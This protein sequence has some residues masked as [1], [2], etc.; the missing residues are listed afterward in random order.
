[1]LLHPA[2][3]DARTAMAT[4]RGIARAG[5]GLR[6]FYLSAK[7]CSLPG[8]QERLWIELA[9]DFDQ[10]CDDAGPPRLVAGA[11][12]GAIAAMEIFVKQQIVVPV[13]IALEFLGAPKYRPPAGFVAQED[14][15]QAIGDLAGD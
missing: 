5:P 7:G 11:D 6:R 1:M 9:K 3:K 8:R 12:P 4:L 14:P 10:Q 13:R 15:S 2:A